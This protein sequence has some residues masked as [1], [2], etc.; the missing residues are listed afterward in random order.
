MFLGLSWICLG[1]VLSGKSRENCLRDNNAKGQYEEKH[2][3]ENTIVEVLKRP[4]P[5]HFHVGPNEGVVIT[6]VKRS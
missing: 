6:I 3:F 4:R 2:E 1:L 5:N